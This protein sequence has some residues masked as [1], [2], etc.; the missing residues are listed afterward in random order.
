[1]ANVVIARSDISSFRYPTID[2][3]FALVNDTASTSANFEL[4][5][6][7]DRSSGTKVF[8]DVKSVAGDDYDGTTYVDMTS[9]T[10]AKNDMIWLN[11]VGISNNPDELLICIYYH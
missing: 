5:F 9:A 8:D 3:V 1:M 7:S 11:V 10:I 6:G 2:S 4:Y